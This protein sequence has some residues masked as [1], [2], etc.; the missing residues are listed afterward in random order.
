MSSTES[1]NNHKVGG[2]VIAGQFSYVLVINKWL[3]GK[4]GFN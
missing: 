1:L 2:D 4:K 3:A